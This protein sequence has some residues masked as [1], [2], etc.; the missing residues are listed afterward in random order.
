MSVG[1]E[2]D[3]F[4]NLFLEW[5]STFPPGEFSE[6][7]VFTVPNDARGFHFK[8]VDLPEIYLGQ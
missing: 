4:Y 2:M 7:I 5:S 3:D 6:E 8:F 1:Y